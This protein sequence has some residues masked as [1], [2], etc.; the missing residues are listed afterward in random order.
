MKV[1][2]TWSNAESL[3]VDNG[4]SIIGIRDPFVDHGRYPTVLDD[5]VRH[6]VNVL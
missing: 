3:S 6:P 5:D 4:I 1:D 2:E